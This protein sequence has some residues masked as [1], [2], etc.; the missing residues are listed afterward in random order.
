MAEDKDA[1]KRPT[2]SIRAGGERKSKAVAEDN[3]SSV[4]TE[5]VTPT[6][7]V[8]IR[9]VLARIEDVFTSLGS[10]KLPGTIIPAGQRN[11]AKEA[12]EYVLADKLKKLAEARH[13]KASEAAEKAGVFGDKADY[14]LG[15]T[16]MVFSDPNFSINVKMGNPS[17]MLKR[18]K[19]EAAAATYLGKKASE[20]L[21]ECQGERA[22]T[23]QIIVSMK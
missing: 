1:P 15:D 19:V 14:V 7:D 6:P 21:E 18:E 11:N 16:V 23:K 12:A 10:D 17:L 9:E 3:L 5:M 2:L 8:S 4:A 13:K 20:F 22:A